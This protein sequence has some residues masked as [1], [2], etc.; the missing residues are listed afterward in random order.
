MF[1]LDMSVSNAKKSD[2][3]EGLS[4][5]AQRDGVPFV[6]VM[7]GSKEQ[8]LG[9]FR[10]KAKEMDCHTVQTEPHSPW[11][12]AAELVIR[13]LKCSSGQKALQK[14]SPTTLWDHCIELESILRSNTAV[15]H[16]ELNGQVPEKIMTGQTA[17][18]SNLAEYE[19]YD[20]VVYWKKTADYPESKECYGRWMGPAIDIGCSIPAKILQE[21][22]HVIYNGTHQPLTQD[23]KDSRSEQ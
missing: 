23:E 17:D 20:W 8:T 6:I 18:I 10:R 13:E 14:R 7:D 19:W 1:R 2:A 16:P 15:F 9:P 11:E 5:M 4:L 3:H 12:N 21:N 22:G